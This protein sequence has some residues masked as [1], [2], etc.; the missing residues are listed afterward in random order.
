[1]SSVMCLLLVLIMCLSSCGY[2]ALDEGYKDGTY[3]TSAE[4]YGGNIYVEVT[5]IDGEITDIEII[6]H[7][8]SEGISDPAFERIPKEVIEEQGVEGVDVVGGA[9]KTSEALI[10]AIEEA[11]NE[12]S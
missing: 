6:D 4:G 7:E 8:E 2:D 9:T 10:E 11:L 5:I 3:E 1:M 12:A